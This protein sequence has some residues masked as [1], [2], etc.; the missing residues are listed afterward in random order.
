MMTV[1]LVDDRPRWVF[2]VKFQ[3]QRVEGRQRC[4]CRGCWFESPAGPRNSADFPAWPSRRHFRGLAN[5]AP[6]SMGF[7]HAFGHDPARKAR[8]VSAVR[9]PLPAW[10]CKG[11]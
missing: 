11:S 6:V 7:S 10:L 3:I 9:I 4:Q 2:K 1:P 8:K 5:A